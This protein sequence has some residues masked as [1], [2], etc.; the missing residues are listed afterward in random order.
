MAGH[1]TADAQ[2]CFTFNDADEVAWRLLMKMRDDSGG[3][4]HHGSV[5]TGDIIAAHKIGIIMSHS[6]LQRLKGS[7]TCE[8]S[9]AQ[10]SSS[11][12]KTLLPAL[13][14]ILLPSYQ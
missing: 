9:P 11:D 8:T 14:I 7:S 5:A 2:V 4:Q 3:G 13:G 10:N 1:L 6:F 12:V